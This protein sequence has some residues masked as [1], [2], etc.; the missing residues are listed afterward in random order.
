M[1]SG[2]IINRVRAG[3]TTLMQRFDLISENLDRKEM[4]SSI[5]YNRVFPFAKLN[6]Q[7]FTS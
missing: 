3:D 5:L 7:L 2:L 4:K 1:G 6:K